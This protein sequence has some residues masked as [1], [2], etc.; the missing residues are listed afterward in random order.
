MTPKTL[1]LQTGCYQELTLSLRFV[2]QLN[3]CADR[4]HDDERS[5]GT[6]PGPVGRNAG[7]NIRMRTCRKKRAI[8]IPTFAIGSVS[9]SFSLPSSRNICAREEIF[10][11]DSHAVL[12]YFPVHMEALCSFVLL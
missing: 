5:Y 11:L 2:L 8:W 12:R 4:R 9:D 6:S 10:T 7:A 1:P 3:A